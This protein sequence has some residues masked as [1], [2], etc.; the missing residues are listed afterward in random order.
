MQAVFRKDPQSILSV[1]LTE[2]GSRLGKRLRFFLEMGL[3]L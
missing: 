1:R 2:L 3:F